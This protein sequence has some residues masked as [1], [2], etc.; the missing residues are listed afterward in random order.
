MLHIV[1]KNG[2]RR[3]SWSGGRGMGLGVVMKVKVEGGR[4]NEGCE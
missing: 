2:W 1:K 3:K 4:S